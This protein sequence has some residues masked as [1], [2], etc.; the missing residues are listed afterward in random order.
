MRT[1]HHRGLGRPGF[2]LTEMLVAIVIIVIV[3]AITA[4]LVPRIGQQE[5]AARGA[6]R[7]QRWLLIAK[8]RA[9]SERTPVGLRL[10]P[11]DIPP[12]ISPTPVNPGQQTVNVQTSGTVPSTGWPWRIQQGTPLL[13]ADSTGT[14]LELVRVTAATPTSFTAT[15]N[16]PHS[17]GFSITV[18]A[19][20]T[21]LEYIYQPEPYRKGKYAGRE[22]TLPGNWCKFEGADFLQGGTF[23]ANDPN[24]PVQPGDY[25]EVYGG[26]LVTQIEQVVV[27]GGNELLR[28]VSPTP[29]LSTGVKTE[30][31][32]ILRQPRLLQGESPLKLPQ[33]IVIDLALCQSIT[34]RIFQRTAF[35]ELLFS[36]SGGLVGKGTTSERVIL[37]VRDATLDSPMQGSPTLI[38]IYAGTGLIA[39]HPV[40][41]SP[42][43]DPYAFTKDPRSSGL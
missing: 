4:A 22:T 24:A 3:A 37:W 1:F 19:Y 7:L 18:L 41:T 6:D 26:G 29:D 28:T 34:M 11:V 36:P 40:D 23:S 17:T 20:V 35:V 8:Q 9:L 15:F 10:K 2:T 12:L 27:S 38:T 42:G 43:G 33:D 32:R 14:N 5:R 31:Y 16:Q 13:I 30:N 21:E 39:A 25:L